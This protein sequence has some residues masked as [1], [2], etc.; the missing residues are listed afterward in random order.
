MKAVSY[1]IFTFEVVQN[2]ILQ[3]VSMTPHATYM[4]NDFANLKLYSKMFYP[5][6][7]GANDKF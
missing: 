2:F 3:Y 4:L 6:Y 1:V 5:L 7:Q